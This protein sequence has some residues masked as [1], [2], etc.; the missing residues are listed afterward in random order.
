MGALRHSGAGTV[1]AEALRLA[2]SRWPRHIRASSASLYL[3]RLWERE[4]F[5]SPTWRHHHHLLFL[6]RL[7]WKGCG[8]RRST[9][10]LLWSGTREDARTG[11]VR[12]MGGSLMECVGMCREVSSCGNPSHHVGAEGPYP[13]SRVPSSSRPVALLIFF[14]AAAG[15]RIIA[16]D[17]GI[18]PLCGGRRRDLLVAV[19]QGELWLWA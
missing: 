5:A 4:P 1:L 12:L 13:S 6:S 19:T 14:A 11:A 8:L 18:G 7:G 2:G 9:W 17:L 10:R 16:A 3:P 15:A